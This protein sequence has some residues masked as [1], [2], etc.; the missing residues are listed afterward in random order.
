LWYI[1]SLCI[2]IHTHTHT[3]YTSISIFN[4]GSLSFCLENTEDVENLEMGRKEVCWI[5]IC[6]LT[7]AEESTVNDAQDIILSQ[8]CE[9]KERKGKNGN[10][11]GI[12]MKALNHL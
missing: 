2:C 8:G 12:E 10:M 7:S 3:P 11:W 5:N 6:M 4:L 1:Y 9:E